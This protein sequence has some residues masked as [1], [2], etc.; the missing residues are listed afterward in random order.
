MNAL[1]LA[2]GR[3]E[4]MRPLTD[5][6]PKPLL[7]V[8]GRPLIEW[9]LQALADGGVRDVVVNTAWLEDQFPSALGD[10]ARWGLR[11]RYS[12]EGREHGGALETAGGMKKALP[13][14]GE[15]FWVVSGDVFL[16]D[17]RFDAAAV[18]AFRERG[19]LAHLW[20]V[21]NPPHHPKGDFALRDG[22]AVGGEQAAGPRYTWASVG[23]FRRAFVTELMH[24]LPVGTKAP[25]RPYLDAAIARGA[26][27][28]EHYDGRWTDVGT[29]ERLA[30][31]Q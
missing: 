25:L 21:D 31:L 23:L 19:T 8:R 6:T 15:V 24:D 3:G 7:P 29:A 5:H 18:E 9:H 11:L 13:A 16:P 4:R 17:F 10:G 28:A 20:L 12:F 1:I 14:L 27:S 30:A 22:L 2:A 26:L